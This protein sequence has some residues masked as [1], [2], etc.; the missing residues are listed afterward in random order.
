MPIWKNA[1]PT[2][3][4]S[5]AI[6]NM[7]LAD[8]VG[9]T[10]PKTLSAGI[11]PVV[12]GTVVGAS[13]TSDAFS[14]NWLAALA[15]LVGA[16]LIQIGS[17]FAN[18]AFD[19][20]TGVDG[21]HRLGPQRAVSAGTISAKAMFRATTVVL[22]L[23]LI[24]GIYLA[25]LSGPWLLVLGVISLVCAV[26]YTGGPFPLAYHGLGD[27]F[28]LLF[29]GFFAVIGSAAVQAPDL[30]IAHWPLHWWTVAAGLGFQAMVII[31]VNNQRD[32]IGDETAHKRT[33]AVRLGPNLH[34]CY[35]ACLHLLAVA[36]IAYSVQGA[37]PTWLAAL[38]AALHIVFVYRNEGRALNPALGMAALLELVCALAM[39]GWFYGS[40]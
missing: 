11:A 2:L 25:T 19:A 6:P 15:C 35:I 13:T 8:W 34:R 39:A 26:A 18:D 9:A 12:L 14:I 27:L 29:F 33:L 7:V 30:P 24:P 31:A 37:W 38:G 40:N 1:N 4:S 32:I 10:R 22:L 20:R 16:L 28:V 17:N 5:R 21:E 23:A 36:C 3:I